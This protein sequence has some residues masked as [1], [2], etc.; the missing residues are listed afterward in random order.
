VWIV[1]AGAAGLAANPA[2]ARTGPA[3]PEPEASQTV[4]ITA[5]PLAGSEVDR[6]AIPAPVQ[7][8]TA[9]DIE[10]SHALDLTAYMNRRLGSVYVNDIQNNPLQPDINYR[11]YTASPLLGTPQGLSLYMDGV[12]LNQPFGDVVSWDLIPRE[13][14]A[15]ITLMPG[16]NPLFG[17]NTLGGA[18]SIR[19]KS[20]ATDPGSAVELGYG[21]NTRWQAQATTGGLSDNGFN[22]FFTANRFNDDGWR[23]A[24]PSDA[25]QV[26][27]KVG[28]SNDKTD[29][30]LTTSLADTDLTGNGLQEQRFLARD[31][32]SVYTK[33]DNTRN[34]AGL[35]NLTALH[36]ITDDIEFSGNL[37]YRKITSRSLNGDIN[38]DSLTESVYQPNAAEQ[39][40]LA[41]A[42]YTGFPTSG[43]NAANTPFPSW[44]CIADILLNSEPN[45][46]CNGLL[47]RSRTEQSEAGASG[48]LT[49]SRQ[50]GGRTNSF[51]AGGAYNAN[52]AHFTQTSQ[53]GYLMP[54]RGVATADGPG[55]FADG[56]QDSDDAYDARV[57]LSGRTHVY[58]LYATDTLEVLPTLNLIVSGRYDSTK[59]ENSDALTPSGAGS[60][61][62]DHRFHRFNPAIG[63]TWNP[64]PA[65]GAYAAYN[66]GSRAPSAIELGCSDPDNPCRL[67]N[68][69]AG[70]PPL[71]QVVTKTL[72]AG[73]RGEAF[74]KLNWNAGLFRAENHDDIMFVA[75]SVSGFGYFR[76][77]GETRRQG[78]ELG[79]TTQFGP[80]SLGASY[81]WLD[82]TYRSEEVVAGQGNSTNDVGPGF[83]GVITVEPGDRIPLVPHQIFKANARWEATRKI[84]FD[85][86]MIAVD[87]V[88]AR[89]NENNLHQ[90]DG[91]FYLGQGKTAGYA[92]LNLGAE[93]RPAGAV[94]LFV[95]V[96]NVFDTHY[97]T[98]A[99]LG[100]TGFTA[101]GAFVARP[102]SGPVID[103]ERPTLGATFYAPGAPRLFW[104]G[105]RYSF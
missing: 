41:N 27:G 6:K 43:E 23:D 44:R 87:G 67:P 52:R 71:D 16:S 51:T 22:W 30:A 12:R 24:S 82:A 37:Y 91:A 103:G 61:T 90:P 77:F 81:T 92:V 99:Q 95:Q 35:A 89:G 33:P 34:H 14:I 4:V 20:G 63:V 64:A 42:G 80:V 1:S 36:H 54:D 15:A 26:F 66:E 55:A 7:T 83:E 45:E 102:F 25:T 57:D 84:S 88:Y 28:W 56:T 96:S 50:L 75:D 31:Y 40:A 5:T 73:I 78:A 79:L 47:N 11:G 94:K 85:A 59:V 76:N 9:R 105:I 74:G 2:F 21:S 8:A 104:G 58:S 100:S 46:T 17:L 38:D 18:L 101:S 62:G 32:A 72:E 39:I 53:F 69:L 65:F 48:Q 93:Y 10:D 19:T 68:A 3:A 97:N 98:A 49:F 86:D 60:L 70:D 13:A 29:I